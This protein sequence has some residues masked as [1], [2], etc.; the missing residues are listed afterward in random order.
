MTTNQNIQWMQQGG[1]A[2]VLATGLPANLAE[3]LSSER[4]ESLRDPHLRW[5]QQGGAAMVLA[6]GL[7]ANL[8]ETLTRSEGSSS[9]AGR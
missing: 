2:M 3:M 7:P 9:S 8:A 5:L 4:A 1:A 6:T